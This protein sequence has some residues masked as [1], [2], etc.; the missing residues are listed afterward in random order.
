MRSEA[1]ID[2]LAR[3]RECRGHSAPGMPARM[4]S[5]AGGGEGGSC[6]AEPTSAARPPRGRPGARPGI[7][8]RAYMARAGDAQNA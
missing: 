6:P 8:G 3:G 2:F 5:R 4:G 7:R 1:S